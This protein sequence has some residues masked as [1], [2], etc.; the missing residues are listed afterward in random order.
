MPGNMLDLS[1]TQSNCRAHFS[2]ARKIR[3]SLIT[4]RENAQRATIKCN[5]A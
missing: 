2:Q 4:C 1:A 5:A 3:E